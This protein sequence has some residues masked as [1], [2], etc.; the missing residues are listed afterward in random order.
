MGIGPL[1]FND[2]KPCPSLSG[3]SESSYEFTATISRGGSGS[4]LADDWL[5]AYAAARG[6]LNAWDANAFSGSTGLQCVKCPVSYKGG[7]CNSGLIV[8]TPK[9]IP[10][11]K[12]A[13]LA[14]NTTFRISRLCK[15]ESFTVNA[16]LAGATGWT[17]EETSK[18]VMN[19][20]LKPTKKI[21]VIEVQLRGAQQSINSYA[22]ASLG[23]CLND[24]SWDGV[25]IGQAQYE[26]A[27]TEQ[28]QLDD[29][30][31]TNDVVHKIN[32]RLDMS[33]NYLWNE[34]AGAWDKPKDPAGN[35]MFANGSFSALPTFI[36]A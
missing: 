32:V 5:D 30:T 33:W 14:A 7:D 34:S 29:G 10:S 21:S 13:L 20:D 25:P 9:F 4:S 11:W 23:Q 19:T 16:N 8:F 3:D 1:V 31:M 24:A 18:P 2:Y 15:T 26:G 36:G 17:W 6:F 35:Y 27:N 28:R 12:V 22:L